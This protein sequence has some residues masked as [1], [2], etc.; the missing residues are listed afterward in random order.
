MK[1]TYVIAAGNGNTKIGVAINV[2]GRLKELQTGSCGMILKI[3]A[4]IPED[5]E[6]QLHSRFSHLRINGEWFRPD[7]S[8]LK[9]IKNRCSLGLDDIRPDHKWDD[10]VASTIRTALGLHNCAHLPVSAI[11]KTQCICGDK[12]SVSSTA[13][14]F[15]E[16]I[17]DRWWKFHSGPCH[18]PKQ[19][20]IGARK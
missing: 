14:C 3:L 19:G 9:Y 10:L 8:F 5:C 16:E 6:R 11:I 7:I 17:I 4:I 2:Y 20:K 15:A 18:G 12:L 1:V 13:K